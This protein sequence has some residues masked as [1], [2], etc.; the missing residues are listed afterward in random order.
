MERDAQPI[1]DVFARV[2]F[3]IAMKQDDPADRAAMLDIMRKDG[4]LVEDAA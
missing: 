1:G 4:W 3:D 2:L